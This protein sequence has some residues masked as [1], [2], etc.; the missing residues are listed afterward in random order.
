MYIV[1]RH[2]PVTAKGNYLR[3]CDVHENNVLRAKTYCRAINNKITRTQNY[4]FVYYY[5]YYSNGI[6]IVTFGKRKHAEHM[7]KRTI[8]YLV[9][10]AI[11]TRS[12]AKTIY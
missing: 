1:R 10:Q 12:R 7:K 8:I 3:V 4:C 2:Y 6:V 9:P 5:Y 11:W